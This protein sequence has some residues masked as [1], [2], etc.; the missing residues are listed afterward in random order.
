MAQ[1]NFEYR[2]H[3]H[4]KLSPGTEIV[5]ITVGQ[6]ETLQVFTV[7]KDL[8]CR[9]SEFFQKAFNGGFSEAREGR[10][11]LPDECPMVFEAFYEWLY[12]GFVGASQLYTNASMSPQLFWFRAQKMADRL[13]MDDLRLNE[14]F[15]DLAFARFLELFPDDLGRIP[16][17]DL[18]RD[19]FEDEPNS[20]TGVKRFQRRLIDHCTL[21]I[22]SDT[23]PNP[24]KWAGALGAHPT[25]S[26]G[27]AIQLAETIAPARLI[28]HAVYI[29]LL[30]D[31]CGA[32]FFVRLSKK[33][34]S[35]K[36]ELNRRGFVC[37]RLHYNGVELQGDRRLSDYNV[38][39]YSRLMLN[40]SRETPEEQARKRKWNPSSDRTRASHFGM[41]PSNSPGLNKPH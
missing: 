3:H 1:G 26:V 18:I 38:E 34:W 9:S 40:G 12:S 23:G 39:P 35:L 37:T 4:C 15:Q 32:T 29:F 27:V 19:V 13:L 7:H 10:M 14:R 21:C 2:L 16:D 36:E 22:R 33:V 11:T 20:S 6:P 17:A 28:A 5:S 24:T 30:K 8:I 25:F 41:H 31:G